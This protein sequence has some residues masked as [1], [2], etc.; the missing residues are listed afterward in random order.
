MGGADRVVDVC[1]VYPRPS[2]PVVESD[3]AWKYSSFCVGLVQTGDFTVQSLPFYG[4]CITDGDDHWSEFGTFFLDV[5]AWLA[6]QSRCRGM[7]CPC[8]VLS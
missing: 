7:L 4:G 6:G 5:A 3:W 1:D 2:N 8:H